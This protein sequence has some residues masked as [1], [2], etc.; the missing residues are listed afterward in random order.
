MVVLIKTYKCIITR[1]KTLAALVDYNKYVLC[2]D[3]PFFL[4][5][6]LVAYT[7]IHALYTCIQLIMTLNM[8]AVT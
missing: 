2:V 6:S 3:T 7:C 4:E 1:V 8:E 5:H